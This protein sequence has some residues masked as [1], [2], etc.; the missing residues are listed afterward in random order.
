MNMRVGIVGA[1]RMG[2]AL[3]TRLA[4]RGRAPVV[5]NRTRRR[6][7]ILAASGAASAETLAA[8][9]EQSDLILI[10]L[11]DGKATSE[12]LADAGFESAVSGK[13]LVQATTVRS[14]EARDFDA[15]ASARNAAALLATIQSYPQQI[16]D[17]TSNLA[18]SGSRSGFEACRGVFADLAETATWLGDGIGLAATLEK[19]G[20]SFLYGC[21]ASFL[22]SAAMC[23]AGNVPLEL[24]TRAC[25]RGLEAQLKALAAKAEGGR[26]YEDVGAT[27]SIYHASERQNRDEARELGID[28]S[29]QEPVLELL[30]LAAQRHP[31]AEF[32]AAFEILRKRHIKDRP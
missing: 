3:A 17:G 28:Q 9:A 32:S 10:S 2:S 8:L 18:C 4:A 7:E 26:H 22:H 16:L 23:E 13:V 6:A 30:R 12:A 29:L 1:G 21:L 24:L 27:I 5:W 25:T 31:E 14:S 20:L 15:W 19:A 11:T